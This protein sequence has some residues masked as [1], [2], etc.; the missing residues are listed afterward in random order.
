MAMNLLI[1]GA[2][3]FLAIVVVFQGYNIFYK[4]SEALSPI[5]SN[6]TVI[7]SVKSIASVDASDSSLSVLKSKGKAWAIKEF[8]TGSFK[9]EQKAYLDYH[10]RYIYKG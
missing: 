9:N 1:R 5:V 7:D 2:T 8:N 4:E 6:P 3:F 10:R